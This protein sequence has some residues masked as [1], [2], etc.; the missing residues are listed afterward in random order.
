MHLIRGSQSN[1]SHLIQVITLC[2]G[3]NTKQNKFSHDCSFQNLKTAAAELKT[4]LATV[5]I[6]FKTLSKVLMQQFCKIF[7]CFIFSVPVKSC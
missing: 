4:V 1:P 7:C 2:R 3:K 6:Y 5:Y